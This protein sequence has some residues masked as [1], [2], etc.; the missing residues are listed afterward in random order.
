VGDTFPD[1]SCF[2]GD[3]GAFLAEVF[4]ALLAEVLSARGRG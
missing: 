2:E 3:V 4:E 1:L